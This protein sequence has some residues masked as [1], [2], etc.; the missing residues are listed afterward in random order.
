[1]KEKRLSYIDVSRG[2][3]LFLVV[4]GHLFL[5]GSNT[6]RWI[7]SFHMPLFFIIS[8]YVTNTEKYKKFKDYFLRKVKLLILPY[9]GFLL[10]G[11]VIS[12]IVK[13][14]RSGVLSINAVKQAFYYTQ[15]ELFHVGQV[16]FLIALFNTSIVFYFV[17][18]FIFNKIESKKLLL[19]IMLLVCSYFVMCGYYLRTPIKILDFIRLPFKFDVLPMS[20]FFML[21]GRFLKKFTVLDFFI[22]DNIIKYSSLLIFLAINIVCGVLING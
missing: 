22:S 15:P 12:V 21:F 2:I 5:I 10:L 1:M 20:L 16:W 6:S 14:W 8:G 7:F 11:F 4:F 3:A 17:D 18:K 13:D 19:I 9:I